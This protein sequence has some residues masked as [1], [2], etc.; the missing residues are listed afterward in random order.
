MPATFR[1][2]DAHASLPMCAMILLA[3]IFVVFV[4]V[5]VFAIG[6]LTVSF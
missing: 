3:I 5:F 6:H 1:L 2:I 4:F